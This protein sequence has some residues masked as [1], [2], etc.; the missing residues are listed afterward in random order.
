MELS[1]KEE[2]AGMATDIKSIS[3][4]YGKDSNKEQNLEITGNE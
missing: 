2:R 4:Q 1:R 3:H